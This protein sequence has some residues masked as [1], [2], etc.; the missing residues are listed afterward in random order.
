MIL[1]SILL[2]DGSLANCAAVCREWQAVIE[3]HN[4]SWIKLTIPRLREFDSMT[5][6]TQIHVRYLWVCLELQE[7]GGAESTPLEPELQGMSNADSTAIKTA[8]EG[9]FETLSTWGARADLVLDISIHSPSD[10]AHWF[11][12]LSF[13]PDV[14]FH[15][16]DCSQP[17]EHMQPV[18]AMA[19]NNQHRRTGDEIPLNHHAIGKVFDDIMG[20]RPFRAYRDEDR[21]WLSL[22]LVPAVT[23]VILRQQTRRRWKPKALS[24]LLSQFPRLREIHYEPWREWDALKQRATDNGRCSCVQCFLGWF[25]VMYKFIAMLRVGD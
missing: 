14:P 2:T 4:F 1:N 18:P 16:R 5:R 25:C 23:A 3:R 11:K 10:S 17:S 12:Y 20:K 15:Q 24:R 22:P 21:W 13:E 9:L 6:R 19:N 8:F 7:Y